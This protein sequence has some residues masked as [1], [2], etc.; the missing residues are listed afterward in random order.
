MD[1][2][3]EATKIKEIVQY[4]AKNKG[5]SDLEAWPEAILIYKLKYENYFK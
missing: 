3:R 2:L 5:I 1:I 4:I